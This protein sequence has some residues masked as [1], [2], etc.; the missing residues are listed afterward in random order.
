[1]ASMNPPVT[2]IIR[3]L[4]ALVVFAAMP[5]AGCGG[6]KAA[7][8]PAQPP[9]VSVA[10]VQRA[11]VPVTVDL[12]GRTNAYSVAQVRARVDGIVLKRNFKEGS[13]VKA[14]DRLYKID[15]APFQAALDSAQASLQKSQAALPALTATAGRFKVLL[16]NGVSQMDYD[17]A[18][19][20]RDQATADVAFNR[21]AVQTARINLGY[22][23]VV[24]PITGRI[25]ISQVTEGAFVQ[26]SAATLMT[27]IQQIDPIYVDLTQSSAQGLQLRRDIATGKVNITGS[28]QARVTIFLEDGTQYPITGS[29]QFTDITVDQ[30]TGSVTLRALVRNPNY[31]L[32]PGMFVRA[33]VDE[34][35]DDNALLVPQ[36]AVTHNAQGQATTLVL[37]A[38]NKVALRTIQ[39]T[40]TFGN[41]WVVDSGLNAGEKVIVSGLQKVQPGAL[42]RAVDTPA[43]PTPASAPPPHPASA[44]R[45][46]ASPLPQPAA[47]LQ[48]PPPSQNAPSAA[49]SRLP[50][51]SKTQAAAR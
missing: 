2:S 48:Q 8:P 4:H 3:T 29:L 5:L 42:V 41:N 6:G 27:T 28:N 13:D 47:A 7:P 45:Q 12:P 38:D 43:A 15:P 46:P 49:S 32:L 35:V 25:G 31:V 23:D 1:M 18:V 51:Q 36:V 19:S 50:V 26:A 20:T 16:G 22:T 24:A 30:N 33:R 37:G 40:R 39:A 34:G 10:T 9:E 17:T 14:G 11:S 21:A 44:S